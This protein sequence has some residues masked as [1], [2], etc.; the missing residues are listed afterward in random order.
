MQSKIIIICTYQTK[1]VKFNIVFH[2]IT[3][4]P[5]FHFSFCFMGKRSR[6]SRRGDTQTN[7]QPTK[8]NESTTGT[9]SAAGLSVSERSEER[10]SLRIA[11]GSPQ[12]TPVEQRISNCI[13]PTPERRSRHRMSERILPEHFK[14][15][16]CCG[17]PDSSRNEKCKAYAQRNTDEILR[18]GFDQTLSM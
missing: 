2:L 7:S 9:S 10:T 16:Q 4:F 17:S 1:L 3:F 5:D 14:L 15:K 18:N 6:V 13:I 8:E 12:P 11:M